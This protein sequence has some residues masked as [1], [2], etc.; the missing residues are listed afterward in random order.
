MEVVLPMTGKLIAIHAKDRQPIQQ[1][2]QALL[3]QEPPPGD[4][5][6]TIQDVEAARVCSPRVLSS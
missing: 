2:C 5:H 1:H 4:L 6:S 3:H